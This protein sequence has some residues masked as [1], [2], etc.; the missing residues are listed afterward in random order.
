MM[1][2]LNSHARKGGKERG[3]VKEE[4]GGIW[5]EEEGKSDYEGMVQPSQQHVTPCVKGIGWELNTRGLRIGAAFE[6]ASRY[7]LHRRPA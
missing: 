2:T 5:E 3:E 7:R 6:P 1:I 4:Y